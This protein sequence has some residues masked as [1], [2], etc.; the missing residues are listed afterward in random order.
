MKRAMP[1][2]LTW[3][4]VLA[5]LRACTGELVF[6]RDGREQAPAGAVRSRPSAK[7][8]ELCLFRGETA[9]T[10]AALIEQLE[11]LSATSGRRFMASAKATIGDAALPIEGIGDEES[12]GVRTAVLR[13]RR[14]ALGF[15]QSQQTGSRTT[16]RSKRIKTG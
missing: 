15:N 16:L 10:R 9:T 12:D 14:P 7:G 11:G 3:R 5:G 2:S 13:M 6:V 1:Q 8:T 4:D